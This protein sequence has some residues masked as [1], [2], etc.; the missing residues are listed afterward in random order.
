MDP[1]SIEGVISALDGI[2]ER[3]W[4]E[5]SRVGYFAA[6]YRRVTRAVRDA[7]LQHRF[8]NSPLL[9]RLD[10]TFANRYLEALTAF[11]AGQPTTRSW[12]VA[13]QA[14]ADSGPL[15]VQQLLAGMN[16][17]INLDLGIASA[18]TSPGAQLPQLKPD[19]DRV[20]IILAEQVGAVQT[21]LAVVS[22]RI[23][24]LENIAP[25]SETALINFDIVKAREAAWLAAEHL[26]LEPEFLTPVTIDGLDLTVSVFGRSI[27]YP[28]LLRGSL[29]PIREAETNDVRRVIEVLAQ[30]DG[31]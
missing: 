24:D 29:S 25:H 31:S 22:P 9:E 2:V 12:N 7:L 17:H 30:S 5:R 13:F 23:G 14:C 28:P 19:F 21:D 26:A 8:Q 18:R 11:L 4:N 27:L 10:V 16:A 1:Q 3:A 15:V 6:L 20:N